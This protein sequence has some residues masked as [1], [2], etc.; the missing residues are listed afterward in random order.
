MRKKWICVVLTMMLLGITGC[1]G[2][3]RETSQTEAESAFTE[4]KSVTFTDDLGRT[5]TVENPQRV[6]ALL[7]SFADVWMLAGGEVIAAPDDA[8]E[9]FDLDLPKEAVNLGNTKK[10]SLELLFSADPDFVIASSN[11]R[12]NLD[13][14]ETLEN[15]GIPVAYF[16]V[17][18]FADYLRM[19]KICT[20]ITG[21]SD[22]YESNGTA[23]QAEIDRVIA[24]SASRIA[25]KGTPT[26]L[27]LRASA[28]SIRAVNS[29][30]SVLGEMLHSLGCENI[31]DSDTSLK[32]SLSM[33]YI[34]AQDPD[35]I[36]IVQSGDDEQGTQEKFTQFIAE[37]PAWQE[38]T[39]VKEGRLFFM[40]KRL[41]NLKPNAL[42]DQAYTELEEILNNN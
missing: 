3:G 37:N 2:S 36:F 23:V 10:L 41:Y 25:Q 27:S 24:A 1:A 31:A 35:Y 39:A 15:A 29:D 7:G 9:D 20:D 33:E 32:E 19:L 16:D 6:A 30:G 40:D 5:V 11:T 14:M 42:W 22:L 34:I 17:S 18:D 28:A 13:W 12:I 8:W 21:R 26:V 38:L 4:A